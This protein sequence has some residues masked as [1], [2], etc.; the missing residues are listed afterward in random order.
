MP[1]PVFLFSLAQRESSGL[2]AAV[3]T[4]Q[5]QPILNCLSKA[6]RSQKYAFENAQMRDDLVQMVVE[7]IISN[8]AYDITAPEAQKFSFIKKVLENCFL[9]F[10]RSRSSERE[11][12]KRYVQVQGGRGKKDAA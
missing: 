8:S 12:T 3:N 2:P 6:I 7:K 4:S 9:D 1:W 11:A 5:T 10:C